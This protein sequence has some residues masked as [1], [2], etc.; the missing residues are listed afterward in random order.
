MKNYKYSNR[1]KGIAKKCVKIKNDVNGNSRYVVHFLDL[2]LDKYESTKQTRDAGLA[3]Y[4]GRD[5]GGGF[6]FQSYNL[7]LSI[8][9][10]LKALKGGSQCQ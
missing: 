2:G 9:R 6:A 8:K 10:I 5:F 4:R 7:N 1:E 3:K